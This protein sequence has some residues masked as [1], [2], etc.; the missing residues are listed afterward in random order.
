[1]PARPLLWIRYIDD[2]IAI[3]DRTIISEDL[4]VTNLKNLHPN[5]TFSYVIS[6]LQE[7]AI[8]LDTF[9]S[10]YNNNLSIGIYRKPTHSNCVLNF[11]SNHTTS[12]KLGVAIG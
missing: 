7:G 5:I 8:F 9:I 2:V 12:T 1:M 10:T 6:S 11:Y 4:L 3:C